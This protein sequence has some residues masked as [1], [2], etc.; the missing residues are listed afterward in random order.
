MKYAALP[1]L[2]VLAAC[3]AE[4]ENGQAAEANAIETLS[5]NNLVIADANEV[6][7]NLAETEPAAPVRRTET[8]PPA[9]EAPAA[10]PNRSE[11]ET[12]TQARART[13]PAPKPL[14]KPPAEADAETKAP[15]STCTPE[16]REMGH[17]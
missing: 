14:A 17:C 4:V 11:R 10:R 16:H 15:E 9:A 2:A 3:S 6:G 13:E 5:V 7:S 8:P 12:R 1:L